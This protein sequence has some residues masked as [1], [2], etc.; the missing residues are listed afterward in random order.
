MQSKVIHTDENLQIVLGEASADAPIQMCQGHW[1]QLTGFDLSD[2][3]LESAVR[4][5]FILASK[6][7]GTAGCVKHRCPVCGLQKF[8]Y[9]VETVNAVVPERKNGN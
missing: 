3:E 1:D 9:I 2:K 7:I 5:I 6:T 8:D 4:V